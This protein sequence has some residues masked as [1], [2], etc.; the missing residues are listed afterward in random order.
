MIES[1]IPNLSREEVRAEV[2]SKLENLD[3]YKKK[4]GVRPDST[5]DTLVDAMMAKEHYLP[6][7]DFKNERTGLD[8]KNQLNLRITAKKMIALLKEIFLTDD[9]ELI[10]K[11]PQLDQQNYLF[12]LKYPSNNDLDSLDLEIIEIVQ[13]PGSKNQKYV[14]SFRVCIYQAQMVPLFVSESEEF[15]SAKT[16]YLFE[17]LSKIPE[18]DHLGELALKSLGLLV[19]VA[20]GVEADVGKWHNETSKQQMLKVAAMK[21][22]RA[23]IVFNYLMEEADISTYLK[24]HLSSF[25]ER[26]KEILTRLS[27]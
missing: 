2:L 13:V 21:A 5:I 25:S 19:G 14:F 9:Q 8:V 7:A 15:L 11:I 22:E 10:L 16:K 26:I 4:Y 12:A 18:E 17:E 1:L 27:K 20:S 3:L 6:K 23:Q 24:A